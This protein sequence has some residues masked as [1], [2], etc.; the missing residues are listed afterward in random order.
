M[1]LFEVRQKHS[2]ESGAKLAVQADQ[3]MGVLRL[4]LDLPVTA[5]T[6]QVATVEVSRGRP[7]S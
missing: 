4:D 2:L 7:K 5:R 1:E 3:L 6:E